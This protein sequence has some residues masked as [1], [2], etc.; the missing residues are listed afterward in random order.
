[1]SEDSSSSSTKT[2]WDYGAFDKQY[3]MSGVIKV[4]T[5]TVKVHNLFDPLPEFMLEADCIFVDPP[6]NLG[7]LNSFYTKAGRN[8]KQD[9]FQRF[10]Q[11]LF[12]CIRAIGPQTFFLEM[13]KEFLAD[14]IM[15]TRKVFRY[16]T[17]YNSFYYHKAVNRCYVIH[18]SQQPIRKLALDGRD[19]EEIIAWIC[20]YVP[21]KCI[22]DLCMGRGFV[23]WYANRNKRRFVGTELNSA[24]LAVLIERI[25][26]GKL[27]VG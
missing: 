1:M 9:D 2:K 8:D 14:F 6:W 11:R 16:V 4:G 17:F 5:G 3:D 13:G 12:D 21:F 24:R 15:E 20:A 23:G 7:N 26:Q 25:N 22:G 10:R 18:A 27:N 19:E